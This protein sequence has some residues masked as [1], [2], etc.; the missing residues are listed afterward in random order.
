MLGGCSLFTT[1]FLWF[2]GATVKAREE[3]GEQ[4]SGPLL[5]N[6]ILDLAQV[7]IYFLVIFGFSFPPMVYL[8]LQSSS[9]T[10]KCLQKDEKEPKRSRPCM[11]LVSKGFEKERLALP[12]G[13]HN[14]LMISWMR[15]LRHASRHNNRRLLSVL[16]KKRAWL[17]HCLVLL[18]GEGSD[19][20]S[21]S[22]KD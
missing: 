18:Q 12:Q 16:L 3:V 4:E 14:S 1:Q 22:D 13:L 10:L 11:E 15:I 21:F 2:T 8:R 5:Q 9:A 7:W 20:S 17:E 6:A 19:G